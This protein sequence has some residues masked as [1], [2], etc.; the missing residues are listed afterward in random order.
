MN[1]SKGPEKEKALVIRSIRH[2]ESSRIVTLFGERHGKFA[3]IAKGARKSRSGAALGTIDPP[4]QIEALVYFKASRSV[5]TLGQVSLLEG[6]RNIKSDLSLMAYTAVI[7]QYINRAVTDG[8]PNIEAYEIAKQALIN[9]ENGKGDPRL[10]LWLFQL[11]MIRI[12]GFELNP[13]PC[14]ICDKPVAQIDRRNLLLLDAGAIC[15]HKCK[16]SNGQTLPLS[17]ESVSILRRLSNGAGAGLK[18]LKVSSAARDEITRTLNKFLKYHHPSVGE[19]TALDMLDQLENP[20]NVATRN[21][22]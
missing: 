8:E 5:Q 10:V 4:S 22:K 18:N 6:Y 15:C 7:L 13:F 2:G 16:P 21:H 11:D 1:R 20:E 9:L 14:P 17:G 12:V 3:V 19:L